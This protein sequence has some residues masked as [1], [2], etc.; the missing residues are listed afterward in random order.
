MRRQM[1]LYTAKDQVW[2]DCI[3]VPVW[4]FP[5]F[6]ESCNRDQTM[7]MMIMSV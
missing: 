1:I 4:T 2:D 6:D 7:I 5:L 3:T